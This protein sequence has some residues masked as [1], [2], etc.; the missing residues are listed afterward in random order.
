LIVGGLFIFFSWKE[1]YGETKK[2]IQ[3]NFYEAFLTIKSDIKVFNEF[4][5]IRL[6]H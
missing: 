5:N 3:N 6:F 1:N 4:I 2:D